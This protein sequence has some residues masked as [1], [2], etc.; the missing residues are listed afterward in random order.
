MTPLDHYL[1]AARTQVN[2]SQSLEGRV[3]DAQL[4]VNVN[5]QF[6]NGFSECR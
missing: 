4:P 6:V 1:L 5:Q 3:Q 2:V